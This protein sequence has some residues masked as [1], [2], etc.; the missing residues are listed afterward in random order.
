MA[1][2]VAETSP[3][4]PDP[5]ADPVPAKTTKA[6]K[7]AKPAAKK[8]KSKKA[9][10]NHPK[11]HAMIKEAL[12]ALKERNGSSRQAI[13]KYIMQHYNVGKDEKI[14]NNH[15][16][17]ALRA[18]VKNGTLK[19]SKGTGASGSFRVGEKAKPEKKAKSAEKKP[20]AKATKVAVEKKAKSPKA[21]KSPKKVK[22]PK[23]AKKAKSP[24]KEKSPKKA[25]QA[26]SPKKAAATKGKKAPA[27]GKKTAAPAAET[28]ASVP[29]PTDAAA[30]DQ[31]Q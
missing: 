23:A 19:Q 29:V 14:V 20:K 31:E 22:K 1:D 11:Y 8:S 24:K 27:K 13:H 10:T 15:L 30:S 18:G 12:E 4:G 16:K 3:A 6:A 2:A 28:P 9:P 21:A 7:V 17:L 5:V 26:K 25:K